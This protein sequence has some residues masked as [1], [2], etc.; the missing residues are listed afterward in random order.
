M[1][2]PIIVLLCSSTL[3][4][5]SWFPLKK[6]NEYG[7]EGA[8]LICVSFA[9][10]SLLFSPVY[11]K[12]YQ[13]WKAQKKKVVLIA[14]LGGSANLA[15][16]YSL[17]YGDVVRVMVLF[18]LLP[19]WGVIG[20]KVLLNEVIDLTRWSAVVLAISG[21]I[22]VLGGPVIF[23]APPSW[24]DLIALSSGFLYA[25]TNISFRAF[26]GIPIATKASAMFIGCSLLALM[27]LSFDTNSLKGITAFTYEAWL[28]IVAYAVFWLLPAS[29]GS[30]WAVT[31]MQAGRSSIIIIMEL[32]SAVISAMIILRTPL[33]SGEIVGGFMIV[34]AA[35]LEAT[36]ELR[37]DMGEHRRG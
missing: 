33:T 35:L 30:Q 15:F 1:N 18:Y 3:W 21:A 4:G 8:L 31:Q 10:L 5:V 12:Q 9:C 2:R 29:F 26:Q 27:L 13:I 14:V 16:A 22:V 23:S 20:G 25:M 11:V 32:V 24:I 19:I 34:G 7:F 6:L 36:R 37:A 28:L 17:I